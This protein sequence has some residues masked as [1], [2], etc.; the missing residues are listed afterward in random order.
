MHS[1]SISL[2]PDTHDD[3]FLIPRVEAEIARYGMNE[4]LSRAY[5]RA[6]AILSPFA[7]GRGGR[8]PR[9]RERP[10]ELALCVIAATTN[11]LPRAGVGLSRRQYLSVIR[12]IHSMLAA[13]A[14]ASL[15]KRAS[16]KSKVKAAPLDEVVRLTRPLPK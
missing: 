1:E 7:K 2:I 12:T 6:G 3:L 13:S 5:T 8:D 15:P 4:R 14:G 9:L 11:Y 10:V 16:P